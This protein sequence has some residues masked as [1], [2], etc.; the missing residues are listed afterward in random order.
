MLGALS[1]LLNGGGV[2]QLKII[3]TEL[4]KATHGNEAAIRDLVGQ[5]DT[6]V[7]GLDAQKSQIVTALDAVDRL[8]ARLAAQ[9]AGPG[10]RAG[11][12]AGRAQGAG[13]PARSA[14]LD[15]HRAR[16]ARRGRHHR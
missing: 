8:S 15:A 9:R 10:H 4:N 13:R 5:L 7:G 2:A 1:L 6:F 14:D 11:P 16:P 3:T 12:P